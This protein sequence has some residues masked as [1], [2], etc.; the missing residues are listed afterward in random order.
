VAF[1]IW[2][3]GL[4]DVL[5]TKMG[6]EMG[7]ITEGNPVMAYLF[8]YNASVAVIFSLVISAFFLAV[9]QYLRGH[10]SLA[11]KAMWGLL[12]LRIFIVLLH[13]NWLLRESFFYN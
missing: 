13:A 12:A 9:L 6:L 2:I 1:I 11:G 5:L 10:C 8:A 4:I 3:L 7:V